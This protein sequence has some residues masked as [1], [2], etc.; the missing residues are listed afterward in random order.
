MDPDTSLLNALQLMAEKG[1]SALLVKKNGKAVGIFSER[2]FAHLVALKQ[3]IDLRLPV[4]IAMTK[5]VYCVSL[6]ETVDECMA[7][8]TMQRFRHLP[9]CDQKKDC[10]DHFHR[11]CGEKPD[12]R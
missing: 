4:S 12:R 5:D 7:I 3:K 2:D 8:M 6:D 11:R 10:G 9:V 1:I